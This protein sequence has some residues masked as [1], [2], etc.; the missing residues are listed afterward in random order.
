LAKSTTNHKN[1]RQSAIDNREQKNQKTK[2]KLDLGEL[3]E[4]AVSVA[5]AAAQTRR[6]TDL[7]ADIDNPE[8]DC[9]SR[10][11][12]TE[13]ESKTTKTNKS[14]RT[15]ASMRQTPSSKQTFCRT[16]SRNSTTVCDHRAK[17]RVAIAYQ[18]VSI[19]CVEQ[20][21]QNRYTSQQSA[22]HERVPNL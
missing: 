11:C 21:N 14:V 8:F 17:N 20:F 13:R 9:V 2:A 19:L 15:A 1:K 16:N 18:I 7:C 3:A 5:R 12:A 22:Q 4:V 10:V 6:Q